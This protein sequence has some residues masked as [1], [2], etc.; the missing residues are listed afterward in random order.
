MG[1]RLATPHQTSMA[2][3][4]RQASR[5]R[6]LGIRSQL[7]KAYLDSID[8]DKD[9]LIFTIGDNDTFAIWYAQEIEGYRTDVRSINTQ[10]LVVLQI[11]VL[12][13]QKIEWSW[14]N[15]CRY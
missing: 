15:L 11:V 13:H 2:R 10:L 1:T 6:T 8:E 9:A 14:C 4:K 5:S 7:A 3:P 12:D